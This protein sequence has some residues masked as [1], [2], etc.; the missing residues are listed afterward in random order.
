MEKS[1]AAFVYNDS[2]AVS[3]L[4]SLER[5]L[6]KDENLKQRYEETIDVDVQKGFMILLDETELE[7]TKTDLQWYVPHLPL[8]NPNKPDK[9]RRVCNAAAKFGGVSLNDDLMAVPDILPSLIG[10]IF[11]FRENQIALTADVEATFL[12]VKV[13][14]AD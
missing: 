3:Q 1:K 9:V 6:E 14:L 8:L 7:N 12:Q 13:P 11:R 2:S 5:Q 4:K 10:V